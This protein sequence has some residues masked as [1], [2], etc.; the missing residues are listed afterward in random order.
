MP[1]VSLFGWQFKR[2]EEEKKQLTSFTP[3]ETNDGA[4]LISAG[5]GYGTYV[6]LDGTVRTEAELVTKYREMS[7]Q[8]ECDAAID[9]IVNESISIDEKNIV[10][11]NLE[12]VKVISDKLASAIKE[13]F[14]NCL[15]LLDFDS[16][17]Y[18][19]YRRWYIDGRLYFHVL[20]DKEHPHEGINDD[21]Y[22]MHE[23][24]NQVT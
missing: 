21:R 15:K 11:I 17:A 10:S 19:I 4:V 20:I 8:P 9:E 3:Q 5:S 1:S 2:K 12:K 23:N 16:H 7:L 24:Q 14:Q 6:D 18:D 22:H 13:E